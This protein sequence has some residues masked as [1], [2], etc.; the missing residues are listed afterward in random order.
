[1][2]NYRKHFRQAKE[3]FEK[4]IDVQKAVLKELTAVEAESSF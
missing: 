3:S 4:L 2:A 1:M